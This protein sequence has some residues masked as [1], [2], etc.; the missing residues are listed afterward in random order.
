[1]L[2]QLDDYATKDLADLDTDFDLGA[3]HP[4]DPAP[5]PMAKRLKWTGI[6]PAT[7]APANEFPATD[8]VELMNWYDPE[9]ILASLNGCIQ[10]G[11]SYANVRD[12][13][14]HAHIDLNKKSNLAPAFRTGLR[15]KAAKGDPSYMALHQ[16][17]MVIDLHWLWSKQSS[18]KVPD[19][20]WC[21]LLQPGDYFDFDLAWSFV[22]QN[23]ST[24]FRV[25][26]VLGLRELHQCQL[27]ALRTN[28]MK[29]RF[30]KL[31]YGGTRSGLT[32]VRHA[33]S[34]WIEENPRMERYAG[35]YEHLWCARELLNPATS[36][37]KAPIRN[38]AKVAALMQGGPHLTD[39]T[40][41]DKL[42]KLD[43][44]LSRH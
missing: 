9:R 37:R 25:K 31:T 18:V 30:E 13:Y 44:R 40:V 22:C 1:M 41:R 27:M 6:K 10:Y 8:E 24:E 14:C 15:L 26:T 32:K 43:A 33:I 16:D 2:D 20:E 28:D 29:A 4:F 39:K 7:P 34:Q 5:P 35:D 38:I 36:T 3:P 12:A 19:K 21:S 11:E 23:W 42:A 17:Q